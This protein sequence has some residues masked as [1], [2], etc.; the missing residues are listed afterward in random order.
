M[1]QNFED[2][3]F[4]N[5][6][7]VLDG[8]AIGDYTSGNSSDFAQSMSDIDTRSDNY[9]K[10]RH[11]TTATQS[12]NVTD[13][14]IGDVSLSIVPEHRLMEDPVPS[15]RY[16]NAIGSFSS[17]TSNET[18]KA[19]RKNRS[20]SYVNP[21]SNS[22]NGSK[23]SVE[24]LPPGYDEVLSKSFPSIVNNNDT[25]FMASNGSF[26]PNRTIGLQNNAFRDSEG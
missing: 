6:R 17:D 12:S 5:G 8:E 25:V 4:K 26:N 23:N 9:H 19:I 18:Q 21:N 15:F 2:P 10:I 14:S 20:I 3:N 1:V 22:P 11:N 24:S 16:R 7:P 13:L